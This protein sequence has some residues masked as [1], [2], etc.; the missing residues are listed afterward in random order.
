MK[1]KV[2]HGLMSLI[3]SNPFRIGNFNAK[4]KD[5]YPNDIP[6]FEGLEL[7]FL[8]SQ[9]ELWQVI[10]EPTQMLK[11]SKAYIDMILL[12]QLNIV[13]DSEVLASFHAHCY[14]QILYAK[15]D[16]KYF[17]YYQGLNGNKLK[18]VWNITYHLYLS[19]F[20]HVVNS[21]VDRTPSGMCCRNYIT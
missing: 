5:Y 12:S 3:F 16:L 21:T 6:S 15:F 10:K 9:F 20:R 8:T 17:I 11:N 1:S 13:I 2:K 18:Q 4:F 14:H 7:V 19:C